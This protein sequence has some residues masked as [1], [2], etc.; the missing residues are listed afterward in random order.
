MEVGERPEAECGM[1]SSQ[2][3]K[4]WNQRCASRQHR[5]DGLAVSRPHRRSNAAR[6]GV[7]SIDADLMAAAWPRQ[8][9]GTWI[10]FVAVRFPAFDIHQTGIAPDGR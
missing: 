6:I 4:S 9:T 5:S 10:A 1:L 3:S 2:V 7:R 8:P